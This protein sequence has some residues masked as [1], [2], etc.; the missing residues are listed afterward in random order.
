MARVTIIDALAFLIEKGPGRTEKELAE[1]IYASGDQAYQQHV[2]QDCRRLA[3]A[4]Q[5][6][7]RGGGGPRDP[8]RYYPAEGKGATSPAT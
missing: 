2:N 4:N 8:F 1:A 5:V 7:R 3:D 6:Q